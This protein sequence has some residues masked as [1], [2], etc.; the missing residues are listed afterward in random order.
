MKLSEGL[1]TLM[2]KQK[3]AIV[4]VWEEGV[5]GRG[6]SGKPI[7]EVGLTKSWRKRYY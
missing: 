6:S 4:F 3:I 5:V 2:T 7:V 1:L